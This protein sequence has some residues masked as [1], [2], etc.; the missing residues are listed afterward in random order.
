MPRRDVGPYCRD[1]GAQRT[2]KPVLQNPA[3][4]PNDRHACGEHQRQCLGGRTHGH[5]RRLG[6][7]GVYLNALPFAHKSPRLDASQRCEACR[8]TLAPNAQ[9]ASHPQLASSCC[10]AID[11]GFCDAQ[12]LALSTHSS[13]KPVPIAATALKPKPAAWHIDRSGHLTQSCS[14]PNSHAEGVGVLSRLV[15]TRDWQ[16]REDEASYA[17]SSRTTLSANSDFDG[18]G[19]LVDTFRTQGSV[20][21]GSP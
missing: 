18:F 10:S 13:L 9:F 11:D 6:L 12:L 8:S 14:L 3:T 17:G 4:Y 19:Q 15:G 16:F 1:L 21:L 7:S 2:R 20:K 5:H